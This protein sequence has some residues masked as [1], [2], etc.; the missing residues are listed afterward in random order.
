MKISKNFRQKG[1][2]LLE[3]ALI[4]GFA[5]AVFLIVFSDGG[6]GETI[7][8]LF[9]NSSDSVASV[10]FNSGKS[11]GSSSSGVT[12]TSDLDSDTTS[13]DYET[14]TAEDIS[15]PTYQTRNWQE[16]IMGVPGMY[17]TVMGSDTPDK[18]LVSET[19]LFGQIMNMTDGY[20][21]STKAE[22]GLKDW[23]TFISNMEKA[24]SR[25]N[26]KS[27]YKRGEETITIKRMGNSNSV[28]ITYS[29][30]KEVIYY[31]LSPDANNVMQVE[32]NS[33]KSYSD[34]FSPIVNRG[35]WSYDK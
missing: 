4:L 7:G 35:G 18:A 10:E 14:L 8:N 21:A 28:R 1:Q 16:I 25:N 24:Q 5:A 27:S 31:Q 23:Q 6:F 15:T 19:N 29:D 22:D 33:H 34:F 11:G 3:Y 9:G 26:F 2:G 12:L 32:T 17:S 30:G 13:F 20:L